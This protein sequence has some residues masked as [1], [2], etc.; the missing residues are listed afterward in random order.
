V[1]EAGTPVFAEGATDKPAGRVTSA[2]L[3]F[4]EDVPV[5][6][7]YLRRGYDRNGSRVWVTTAGGSLTGEVFW[8]ED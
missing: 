2:T 8:S 1:P 6:L 3:S 5:A 7:A 4:T